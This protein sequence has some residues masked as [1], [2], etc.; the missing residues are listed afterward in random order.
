M[1]DFFLSKLP[2]GH[3]VRDISKVAAVASLRGDDMVKAPPATTVPLIRQQCAAVVWLR[4]GDVCTADIL[5][6]LTLADR[7]YLLKLGGLPSGGTSKAQSRRIIE[8]LKSYP[9]DGGTSSAGGGGGSVHGGG[10]SS[11][12][13][14]PSPRRGAAAAAAPGGPYLRRSSRRPPSRTQSSRAGGVR[15][16]WRVSLTRRA[17]RTTAVT[18]HRLYGTSAAS[19]P[20]L[21]SNFTPRQMSA[22]WQPQSIRGS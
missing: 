11:S 2:S 9:G 17:C 10:P 13:G 4:S 15:R 5:E 12:V 19:P 7:A 3:A 18:A 14:G 20:G 21:R 22:H 6:R 16:T 1:S 8:H